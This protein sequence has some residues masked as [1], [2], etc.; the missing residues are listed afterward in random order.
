MVLDYVPEEAVALGPD[1]VWTV[2]MDVTFD[3]GGAY[4][5]SCVGDGSVSLYF[6]TGG[7]IIGAGNCAPVRQSALEF[8][9]TAADHI[10][11]AAVSTEHPLPSAGMVRFSFVTSDGVRVIEATEDD[12]VKKRH[13]AWGLF[14]KAQE[15]ITSVRLTEQARQAPAEVIIHMA[16]AGKLEELENILSYGANVE[17]KDKTGLTP[18]MAAAYQGQ[19]GTLEALLAAGAQTEATDNEGY[20]ALIFAAN[21]GKLD[22]VQILIDRGANVN[23]ADNQKSTPVMFAAQHGHDEIVALLLDHKADPYSKGTHGLSA[24]DFTVQNKRRTTE[25]IIRARNP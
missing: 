20:T 8:L 2:V 6:S 4:T 12:L 21:S 17:I 14:Y 13:A 22:C 9:K 7:G 19:T 15:V 3:Q 10:A 18:L 25:A 11:N 5:L 1:K 24:L 23:A 16:A